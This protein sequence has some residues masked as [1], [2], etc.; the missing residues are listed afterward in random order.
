MTSSWI[1]LYKLYRQFMGISVTL[2]SQ[3]C[4]LTKYIG[5]QCVKWHKHLIVSISH[6]PL[7]LDGSLE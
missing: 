5:D 7:S 4:T 3:I 1:S 6:I 2:K